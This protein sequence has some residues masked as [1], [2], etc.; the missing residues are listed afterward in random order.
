MFED[1]QP[2]PPI[3]EL[4][5]NTSQGFWLSPQKYKGKTSSTMKEVR[6]FIA[7]QNVAQIFAKP[8]KKSAL[9]PIIGDIDSWQL[10]LMFIPHEWFPYDDSTDKVLF[11]ILTAVHSI[12]RYAYAF[13]IASKRSACVARCLEDFISFESPKII[14]T[15]NGNEWINKETQDLLATHNIRHLSNNVGDHCTLGI[16]ERFHR[17]LKDMIKR[18]LETATDDVGIDEVLESVISNYNHSEHRSIGCQPAEMHASRDRQLAHLTT[19][20]ERRYLVQEENASN[21]HKDIKEGDYVRVYVPPKSENLRQH[22]DINW[23]RTLYQ[24][25]SITG[26]KYLIV[27]RNNEA[28]V[29]KALWELKKIEEHEGPIRNLVTVQESEWMHKTWKAEKILDHSIGRMRVKYLIKW[30]KYDDSFCTWEDYL[31]VRFRTI[32]TLSHLEVVYLETLDEKERDKLLSK[33]KVCT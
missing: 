14:T 10:D 26:N 19:L 7:K 24:V 11:T 9:L 2:L 23:S 31:S 5:Y 27:N 18:R 15:D 8:P 6:E 29:E 21:K 3:Q 20:M 17:T 16:I 1:D 30:E 4:F 13:H 28:V 32:N 25:D 22:R 33:L 12:S